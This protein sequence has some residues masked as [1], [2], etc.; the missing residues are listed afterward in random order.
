MS[1]TSKASR[2]INHLSVSV[3]FFCCVLTCVFSCSTTASVREQGP[4][5]EESGPPE[6]RTATLTWQ[7]PTTDTDGNPLTDLAG[8]AVYYGEK[9]G[10]YT[11]EIKVPLDSRDLVCRKID[12]REDGKSAPV[13]CT[14]VIRRLDEDDRYFAVRAYTRSGKESSLS[15]EVKK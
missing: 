7:A 15:N 12:A 4:A 9:S 10:T 8:Y 5:A 3:I 13:E 2:K 6:D 14:Y 11:G 1:L